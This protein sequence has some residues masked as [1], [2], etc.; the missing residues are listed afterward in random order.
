[1]VKW[2]AIGLDDALKLTLER[3]NPIPETESATLLDSV[4]RV[5]SEDLFARVDSPSV[6]ASLKDGYA[7]LAKEVEKATPEHPVR[8]RLEGCVTAG[9]QQDFHVTP[10][11]TVR[12]LTGAKIPPGAN[13][14]VSEEFVETVGDSVLIKNYAESGRNILAKGNDVTLGQRVVPQGCRLAPGVV[15][16]LAAAGYECVSVVRSPKVSIVATGDEVVAPGR[17]LHQGKLYASNMITLG[18]WCH[19]YKMQTQMAVVKDD[20]EEIFNILHLQIQDADALLTSG[21]AWTGDRDMVAQILERLGWN[22]IFHRIRIGPGKAVGFGLLKN[23]PVFILPGGPSSNLMG[24]LQIALPG[25]LKLSGHLGPGLPVAKVRLASDL[26]GRRIDWTQ[27]FFGVLEIQKEM[28][29]F[30]PLR[31]G[32]R[33]RAIAE[34]QAIAAIPEGETHLPTGTVIPVQLLT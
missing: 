15:G 19:R 25:L 27:F 21:G 32:S 33:L 22:Q 9:G 29:L 7:V 1:M 10:M 20:P 18:A 11:T 30:H 14:V 12:V 23:K 26:T 13:A 34:A 2:L 17:P 3:I 28:P 5:V 4:D 24:F 6:D 8:L 31:N 16:I